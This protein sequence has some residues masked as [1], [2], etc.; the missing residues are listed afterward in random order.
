MRLLKGVLRTIFG[1]LLIALGVVG[2][3]LPILQGILLI[4]LGLYLLGIRPQWL[5]QRVAAWKARHKK[6]TNASPE[7]P[8][9][10]A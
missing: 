9:P 5:R 1:V 7:P 2:L 4:L 6:P 8:I 10:P 3:F